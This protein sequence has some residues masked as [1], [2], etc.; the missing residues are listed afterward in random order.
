MG[1]G[2]ASLSWTAPLYTGAR[3]ILYYTV[4]YTATDPTIYWHQNTPTG[5]ITFM[6]LFGLQNGLQYT[7]TITATNTFGDTVL[8]VSPPATISGTPLGP[9]SAPKNPSATV[10]ISGREI[11]SWSVPDSSGGYPIQSYIVYTRTNGATLPN[12]VSTI[13]LT[14]T[15]TTGYVGGKEYQFQIAAQNRAGIGPLSPATNIVIPVTFPSAPTVSAIVNYQ[16][17]TV[18]WSIPPSGGSPITGYIVTSNPATQVYQVTN[19]AQTMLEIQGLLVGVAYCF[20]VVAVNRLGTGPAGTS[21]YC[22]VATRTTNDLY[23]PRTNRPSW[24][25]P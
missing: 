18:R 22:N 9:P 16:K 3:S 11:V 15:F 19:G 5:Q 13:G 6:N 17:A 21:P 4:A 14:Y 8:G 20:S 24:F 12:P 2:T 23:G 10:D 1:D 25:S 7:F